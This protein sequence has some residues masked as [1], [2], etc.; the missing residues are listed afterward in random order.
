MASTIHV[1][2]EF[3]RALRSTVTKQANW[4]I[5]LAIL[6]VIVSTLFVAYMSAGE[7]SLRAIGEAQGR[8]YALWVL[9]LMPLIFGLWGQYIGSLLAFEAGAL[10]VDQTSKLRTQTEALEVQVLHGSTYDRLTDLPNRMLFHDRVEQ[11]ISSAKRNQEIMA[12]LVVDMDDF[13]EV[14]NTLG[15]F[16]GDMLLKQLASR[17]RATVREIDTVARLGADEFAV[18]LSEIKHKDDALHVAQ[19][20]CQAV[21]REFI[22]G[23]I[24]LNMLMSI[25]I[26]FFPEHGDD[27]DTLQQ[28]AEVALY[29]AKQTKGFSIEVY[30]PENDQHTTRRLTLMGELRNAIDTG[31]LLLYY[32]PKVDISSHR[33]VAVESLV[34][35][36]H[37]EYGMLPPDE[38]ISLAER[39]GLIRPLTYWVL[40]EAL[41]QCA[42]WQTHG[43]AIDVAVNVPVS[44]LLDTSF[45][46]KLETLLKQHHLAAKRLVVEITES[47]LMEDQEYALQLLSHLSNIGVR[48][49]IDDFGTGYSSLAYLRR[50]PVSEIKID[51]SFVM[52]ML[53]NENDEVIVR[54]TIGL[55]HN[56]G[57][58]V[59]AEGVAEAAILKKLTIWGCNL[60]QGHYISPPVDGNA[61]TQ[62]LG[63]SEWRT[64]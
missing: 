46:D 56:L 6:A 45:P 36:Q 18:L 2:T 3:S 57:M 51:Q 40:A 58:S 8:N 4:G 1:F 32:Q 52:G 34:R 22:L 12:L 20:L 35:W 23:G 31:G 55:A 48:I 25:G 37:P 60:A 42:A 28:K 33:I 38:F 39:T 7:I 59:I 26:V 44:V 14:N 62:L 41:R 54:A 53:E 11:A 16:S 15:H 24:N 43:Y 49:S 19:K 17:L 61:I 50:L 29:L 27:V 63:N 13:K 10:V 47:S 30:S 5:L 9:D 21:E 64:R